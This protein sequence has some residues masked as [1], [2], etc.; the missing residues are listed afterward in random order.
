M[1]GAEKPETEL[2][3]LRQAMETR[4]VIDQA[5]GVLMA[6]HGCTPQEA[7]D[8]LQAASQHTNTKLHIVAEQVTAATQGDPMADSIRAAV[9][10]QLRN[11]GKQ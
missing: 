11:L 9:K 7:W 3:Q 8:V 4:P 10:S 1:S 6:S 2:E 5:H